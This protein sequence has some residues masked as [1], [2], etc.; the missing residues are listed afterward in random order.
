MSITSAADARSHAVSPAEIVFGIPTSR[1]REAEREACRVQRRMSATKVAV[2]SWRPSRTRLDGRRPIQ[3]FASAFAGSRAGRPSATSPSRARKRSQPSACDCT[4]SSG[5]PRWTR[6]SRVPPALGS[7][8][9]STVLD[10]GGTIS[11]PSQPQV[12]TTRRSRTTSTYLPAAM[13]FALPNSTRNPPPRRGSSSAR[14]PF[15]RTYWTGSVSRRKTVSGDASIVITRSMTFVSRA[16]PPG[17]P[18]LLFAFRGGFQRTQTLGPEDFE[19]RPE[20]GDGLGPRAVEALGP[21]APLG[22]EAG[23]FQDAKVLR[24]RGP[25]DVEAA[26]DVADRELL[27]RDEA[28]NRAASRFTECC[29]SGDFWSVRGSFRSVRAPARVRWTACAR[30][31]ARS[32][33]SPRTRLA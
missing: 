29:K 4:P 10:P 16:M 24:D 3:L 23:L 11:L 21:L 2:R 31:Q 12:K 6:R 22:D 26:C 27:A 30:K 17:P 9:I 18:L 1:L 32:G 7:R 19:G 20:L 13:S 25:G 15:H 33:C 14:L 5:S 28:E 8:S